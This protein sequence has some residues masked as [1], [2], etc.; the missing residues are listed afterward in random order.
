MYEVFFAS[1]AAK[2]FRLLDE[3]I[4]ERVS[5]VIDKLGKEPKPR[6]VKKLIG[7]NKLYRVRVGFYRV[8]YEVDDEERKF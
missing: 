6:G 7:Y 2:E 5:L 8:V 4:K 3:K 1:S